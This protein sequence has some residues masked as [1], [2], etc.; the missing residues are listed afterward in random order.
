M[1]NTTPANLWIFFPKIRWFFLA[2]FNATYEQMN[3]L[4]PALI[5]NNIFSKLSIPKEKLTEKV[6]RLAVTANNIGDIGFLC[7]SLEDNSKCNPIQNNK[8][9]EI[10]GPQSNRKETM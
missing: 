8:I 4:T 2:I 10:H 6:S 5:I 7:S 1:I 3:A 9:L